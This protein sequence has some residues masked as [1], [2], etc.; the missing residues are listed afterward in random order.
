MTEVLVYQLGSLGDTIVTVPVYRA[1]RRHFGPSA[2]IRVLHNVPQGMKATPM[3]VLE[4]TDLVDGAMAYT[5]YSGRLA[6][7]TALSL[8]ATILSARP[9]AIVCA[10]PGERTEAQISRDRKF[11]GMCGVRKLYGFHAAKATGTGV[12]GRARSVHESVMRLNRLPLDGISIVAEDLRTPLLFPPEAESRKARHWMTEHLVQ[13]DRP[14]VAVCPGAN[15]QA[16]RWPVDR[17]VEICRRLVDS[18]YDPIVIGGPADVDDGQSLL[19][20]CGAGAS[21]AGQFSVMGSAALIQE[22]DF[23]VGLD[24]GTTHL[25]AAMGVP[26]VALFGDRNPVGQWEPMGDN[27]RIVRMAVPCGGCRKAV[28]PVAGH[29]CMSLVTVDSLWSEIL[30]SPGYQARRVTATVGQ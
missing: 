10:A 23:L 26:A 11:F 15:Q 17:F 9:D 12:R 5:Q 14:K 22:C 2:R 28:C 25:A 21:A 4:G 1:I 13:S 7:R 24:T 30:L 27:H 6:P 16:N 8:A 18:G 19:S 3:G 20:G 29:P